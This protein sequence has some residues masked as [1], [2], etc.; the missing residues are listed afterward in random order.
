MTL[1]LAECAV[2]PDVATIVTDDVIG[3]GAGVGDGVLP[4]DDGGA[5]EALDWDVP[6]CDP[7]PP[8][9]ACKTVPATNTRHRIPTLGFILRPHPN[10]KMIPA[11]GSRSAYAIAKLFT[12]GGGVVITLALEGAVESVRVA[13]AAVAPGVTVLGEKLQVIP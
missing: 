7:P 8:P 9:H 3:V 12:K 1:T 10:S 11:N 6:S 5:A 2:A 13:C 4:T